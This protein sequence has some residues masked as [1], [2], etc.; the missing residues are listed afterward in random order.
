MSVAIA[1]VLA[2]AAV[3]FILS[4]VPTTTTPP[5]TL[6]NALL[7]QKAL[8]GSDASTALVYSALAYVMIFSGSL[9]VLRF[10]GLFAAA[11]G[12]PNEE[13]IRRNR[14]LARQNR[15]TAALQRRQARLIA[16][17]MSR[18]QAGATRRPPIRPEPPR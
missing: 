5:E 14:E 3:V 6:L 8:S 1:A 11:I 12:I 10:L 15:I 7:A 17:Y 16:H 9:F 13:Q 2:A 4:G 18:A